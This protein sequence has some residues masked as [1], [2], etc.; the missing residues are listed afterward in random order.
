M[1]KVTSP[2]DERNKRAALIM[3]PVMAVLSIVSIFKVTVPVSKAVIV[4]LVYGTHAYFRDGIRVTDAK[5]ARFTNGELVPGV[6]GAV[7]PIVSVLL[8]LLLIGLLLECS[9][10]FLRRRFGDPENSN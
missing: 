4:C 6:V 8:T 3:L 2:T 1:P 10:K 7:I 9:V 5:P